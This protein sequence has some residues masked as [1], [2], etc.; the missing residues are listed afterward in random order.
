MEKGYN[1]RPFKVMRDGIPADHVLEIMLGF[2]L[3]EWDIEPIRR[4]TVLREPG[5]FAWS[6]LELSQAGV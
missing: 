2:S 3:P 1:P 6:G 5:V 4:Q